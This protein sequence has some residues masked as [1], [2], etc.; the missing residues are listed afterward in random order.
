LNKI[1]IHKPGEW[2]ATLTKWIG[3]WIGF[4]RTVKEGWEYERIEPS[5][6]KE[7]KL[8]IWDSGTRMPVSCNRIY[9]IT[10]VCHVTNVETRWRH[11]T[12]MQIQL[13]FIHPFSLSRFF[14]YLPPFSRGMQSQRHPLPRLI[15]PLKPES[16][17]ALKKTAQHCCLFAETWQHDAN[18]KYFS[19]RKTFRSNQHL[20]VG[21]MHNGYKISEYETGTIYS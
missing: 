9:I 13:P 21:S 8:Y 14:N 2:Q 15:Q 6:D 19:N 7:G 12:S 5:V 3:I 10:P 11:S 20:I 16:Y 1:H 4:K 18:S 17:I